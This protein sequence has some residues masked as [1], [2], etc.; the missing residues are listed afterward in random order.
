MFSSPKFVFVYKWYKLQTRL[1][2]VQVKNDTF[3]SLF[4]MFSKVTGCFYNYHYFRYFIYL[5]D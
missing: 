1:C 4:G 2:I 5:Q 3:V